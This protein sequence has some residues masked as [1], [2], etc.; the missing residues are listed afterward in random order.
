MNTMIGGLVGVCFSTVFTAAVCLACYMGF[1]RPNYFPELGETYM[2]WALTLFGSTAAPFALLGLIF[3]TL[4][5]IQYGF[6]KKGS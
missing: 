2:G 6:R 4:G 3:D 5:L 1:G